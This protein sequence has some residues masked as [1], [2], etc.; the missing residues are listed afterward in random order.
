[1]GKGVFVGAT[2]GRSVGVGATVGGSVAVDVA[3]TTVAV[4]LLTIVGVADGK[5]VGVATGAAIS[6]DVVMSETTPLDAI[7]FWTTGA[8]PD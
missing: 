4:G 3:G 5:A 6:A 8:A 1:M 2:V 7:T